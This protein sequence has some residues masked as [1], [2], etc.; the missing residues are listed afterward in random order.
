MLLLILC[1][2][3]LMT[4][5]AMV[6]GTGNPIFSDLVVSVFAVYL[7]SVTLL[8]SFERTEKGAFHVFN[9]SLLGFF[10]WILWAGAQLL[11]KSAL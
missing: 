9:A 2:L 5:A 6:A 10:L 4:T 3:S 8:L 7:A 1:A 11:S